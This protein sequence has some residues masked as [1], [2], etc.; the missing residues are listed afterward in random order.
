MVAL[1]N[2]VSI[3]SNSSSCGPC[4][5]SSNGITIRSA[6]PK[7]F[8][9]LIEW[10]NNDDDDWELGPAD[11][12]VWQRCFPPESFLAAVDENDDLM[13][14]CAGVKH[15]D[16]IGFIGMYYVKEEFRGCGVGAVL[17]K[18]VMKYLEGRNLCLAAE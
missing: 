18:T 12:E 9:K 2:P 3:M 17:W 11:F 4:H 5:K 10:S 7:D 15:G 16:N 1:S 13:G 6:Q 8:V 14:F